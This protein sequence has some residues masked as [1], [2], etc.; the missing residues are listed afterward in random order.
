MIKVDPAVADALL[1][2]GEQ[3]DQTIDLAEAALALAA[4]DLP[5][6]DP[7]GY[8]RHLDL[9][10]VEVSA[11]ADGKADR[12]TARVDAL[13][14]VISGRFGY[15]GDS[16]TYDDVQNANLMRAI[17]R[18]RGLPIVLGVIYLHCARSQG[19]SA[20]G[21][22]FPGHFLIR[23][24]AAGQRAIVDPFHNGEP[25]SALELR[26]MLKAAVGPALELH[27]DHYAPLTNRQVLLRLQN[28]IKLRRLR[29]GEV[30]KA[31]HIL[32]AML[33]IAPSEATLWRESGLIQAHLGNLAGAIEAL[34]R[35]VEISVTGQG[36]EQAASMIRR[37]RS[38]LQ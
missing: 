25:R 6:L 11:S 26:R 31:L 33:L 18:R 1:R 7:A 15:R 30:E 37:L 28:N 8:R 21:L 13:S 3:D 2:I 16:E 10:A 4:Y 19:W 20:D 12:L 22:N 5:E 23:L 14:A 29:A 34:E 27:P 35:F 9:I 24:D 36:R 38:Q 32:R 17:D